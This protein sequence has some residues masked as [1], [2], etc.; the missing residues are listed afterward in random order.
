MVNVA[1]RAA[2]VLAATVYLTVPLPLP[3]APL[4]IVTQ[5][6][7]PPTV[8]A[9]QLLSPVTVTVALP[10]PAAKPCPAAFSVQVDAAITKVNFCVAVPAALSVTVAE[11]VNVPGVRGVRET[12]PEADRVSPAGKLPDVTAH[13]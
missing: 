13:V 4:V 7:T 10:P 5:V 6:G 9:G 11:N 2:P 8:H 1:E 3:V 12:A